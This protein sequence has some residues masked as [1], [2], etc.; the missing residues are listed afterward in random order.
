M[1]ESSHNTKSH[2]TLDED[3]PEVQIAE[4]I[5]AVK[6][7]RDN[8]NILV[9]LLPER[10]PLYL[11]RSS[12]ETIRIRGY[13]LAAFEQVGLPEA[14]LPYVLEELENGRDA[15]L[16]A[17]AAKALR[18]LDNPT[19]GVIPFLFKAVENVRGADDS[20]TFENY[21]PQ[22]PL[23]T[24]T[25]ALKEIFYTFGWLGAHASD[26]LADLQTLLEDRRD[27]FSATIRREIEDAIECIR[28]DTKNVGT[29]CCARPTSLSPQVVR[30][31][32]ERG[33]TNSINDV[34][35]ED[36]E[37][38]AL[39]F[40]D[41]FCRSPS[42]VVFFYSRC[43]NPN[44]CSLTVTKLARLQ[45]AI[46]QEGLEGQLQTAAIT[47]DPGYD[48]PRRLRA[49]GQNRGVLFSDKNRFLR[50]RSGFEKLQDYFSLGV[51]FIGS[52]VNRH[53]IELFILDDKGRV[54]A[55]FTRLQWDIQEVLDQ[56]KL[57]LRSSCCSQ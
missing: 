19:N 8:G 25:T 17:A 9:D 53:R 33:D 13:T 26:A 50:T 39:T 30:S 45:Q 2:Q 21:R 5:D 57:L 28:S 37:G 11:N 24:Y 3:T 47:Y 56:A 46:R 43:D 48:L 44:K 12:N 31:G 15:Y 29:D 51:N 7:S 40:R 6:Q 49:Y 16:V 18:G 34:E 55:S 22:W 10:I 54:A 1:S 4:F 35:L 41:F 32:R 52:I 42:I 23:T 14:A 27:D 38:N 36:Q 20:L